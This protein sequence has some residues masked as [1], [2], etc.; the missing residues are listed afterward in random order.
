MSLTT[1]GTCDKFFSQFILVAIYFASF[2]GLLNLPQQIR[3]GYGWIDNSNF[4]FSIQIS[5]NVLN[6]GGIAHGG[7]IATIA[8]TNALNNWIDFV[9]KTNICPKD[10]IELRKIGYR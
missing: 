5:E 8:D 1:T 3:C 2:I 4:E 7:F 9:P 6:T 10:D